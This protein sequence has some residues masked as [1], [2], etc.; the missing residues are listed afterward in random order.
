VKVTRIVEVKNK[1][2][3]CVGLKPALAAGLAVLVLGL[4]GSADAQAKLQA[5]SSEGFPIH[6]MDSY[7]RALGHQHEG[8]PRS[9]IA[10]WHRRG[11]SH[12]GNAV[13]PDF[14]R[15]R[16]E[17]ESM[18]SEKKDALRQRMRRFKELPPEERS[19][20]QE[21]FQ[22]WQRLSPQERK[23]IQEDLEKWR[24]LPPEEKER[25]RRRFR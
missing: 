13:G 19:L 4:A 5:L 2:I 23:K 1:G 11:P 6:E 10:R 25:T 12:D 24:E 21:R 17:W 16:H 14:D 9:Q 20:Y 3:S 22:Q 18:P 7:S 8:D 15:K